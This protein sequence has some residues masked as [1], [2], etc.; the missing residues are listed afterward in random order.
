MRVGAVLAAALV[1]V[2]VG[3]VLVLLDTAPRQAG[4]NYIPE[5]GEA[6]TIE[7]NGSHCQGDQVIPA[8][9]ASLRLLVGTFER[10]TPELSVSVRAGGQTIASGS[11]RAGGKEGHVVIPIEP[12]EALHEHAEVCIKVRAPGKGRR[13]VLYGVP[14][15]VHLEWLRGG[16][17]SWLELA[18]TVAHRFGLGKPFLS[19]AWVL[20]LSAVLLAAAWAVALRTA[21]RELRR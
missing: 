1:A 2:A 19:G 6:L 7:G 10:P 13:T 18:P 21:V 16:E 15:A 4:T 8:D 3:L 5:S 17:E 11:L 20:W 14:G 12:V 9:A